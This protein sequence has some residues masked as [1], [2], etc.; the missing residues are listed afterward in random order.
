MSQTLFLFQSHI[1]KIFLSKVFPDSKNFHTLM[2]TCAPEFQGLPWS[3]ALSI[4]KSLLL[5]LLL[6]TLLLE[7]WQP[8]FFVFGIVRL[9]WS[10]Q[11]FYFCVVI[12]VC[13]LSC[14]FFHRQYFTKPVV[15]STNQNMTQEIVKYFEPAIVYNTCLLIAF[16]ILSMMAMRLKLFLTPQ[17]CVL[18]SLVTSKQVK[19]HILMCQ[20][21]FFVYQML[22]IIVFCLNNRW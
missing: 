19:K 5:P 7:F 3:Y 9:A 2:Y 8:A 17:M 15:P 20:I 10:I 11:H 14:F 16:F 13:K 4:S 21:D 6:I 22:K 18:V 1:V 12:N